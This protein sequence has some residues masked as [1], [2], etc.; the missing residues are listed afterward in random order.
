[1]FEYLKRKL[2]RLPRLEI[3]TYP[4]YYEEN[5]LLIREEQDGARYVVTVDKYGNEKVLY[6]YNK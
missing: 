1:M 5:G 3:N 2:S 4:K 6:N